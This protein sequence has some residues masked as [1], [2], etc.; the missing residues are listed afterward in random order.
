MINCSSQPA[1]N[2]H[3]AI[4]VCREYLVLLPWILAHSPISCTMLFR[5]LCPIGLTKITNIFALVCQWLV[6]HNCVFLEDV[7]MALLM[8]FSVSHT[9]LG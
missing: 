2:K 1:L 9:V 7:N 5:V 8:A 4:D 3:V 6:G